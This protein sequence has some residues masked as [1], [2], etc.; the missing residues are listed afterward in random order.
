MKRPRGR[1]SLEPK[2]PSVDVTVRLSTKQYD[3]TYAHAHAARLT[4]SEWIRRALHA[5]TSSGKA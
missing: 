5:S 1:P 2:T 3:T 4:L